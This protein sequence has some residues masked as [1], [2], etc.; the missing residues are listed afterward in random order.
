MLVEEQLILEL[1]PGMCALAKTQ[2]NLT[3]VFVVVL[4]G[5]LLY[6][7]FEVRRSEQSTRV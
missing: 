4:H 5:E 7:L 6:A 1:L 3:P 2:L